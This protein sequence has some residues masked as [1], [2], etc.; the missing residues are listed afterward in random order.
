MKTSE[1]RKII[2]EKLGEVFK[3]QGGFPCICGENKLADY[4]LP[5]DEEKLKQVLEALDLLK[6]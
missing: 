5:E 3:N 6:E 2:C 1:A 4:M